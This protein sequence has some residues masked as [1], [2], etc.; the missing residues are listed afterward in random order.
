MWAEV[1]GYK[2]Y[3]TYHNFFVNIASFLNVFPSEAFFTTPWV[4]YAS[5]TNIRAY[6]D[7]NVI[8]QCGFCRFFLNNYLFVL[9]KA[10]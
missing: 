7:F 8:L 2:W 6:I 4:V 1:M 5:F 10:G 9:R 3:D